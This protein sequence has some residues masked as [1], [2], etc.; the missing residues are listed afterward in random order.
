V[1]RLIQAHGQLDAADVLEDP[2]WPLARPY[3]RLVD[4][5]LEEAHGLA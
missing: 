5:P 2:R 4:A 1:A 3:R